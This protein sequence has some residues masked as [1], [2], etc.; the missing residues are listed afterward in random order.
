MEI[1]LS[2]KIE[3]HRRLCIKKDIIALNH[4]IDALTYVNTEID[5]LSIIVQQLIKEHSIALTL[6]G[7][8]RK[9]TLL[10]ALLCKYEQ[11]LNA[12]YEYG[13]CEYNL[14]RAKEHEKKRDKHTSF[15][16]EYT[17]FKNEIYQRLSKF[18]R[19]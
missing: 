15:I 2:N 16:Q 10:L 12:E 18:Q 4:W 3:T 14:T 5:S 11:E 6:Q 9:N 17:L 19:R 7:L 1:K 8:R 13:K